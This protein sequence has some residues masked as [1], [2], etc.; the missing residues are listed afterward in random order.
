MSNT[1]GAAIAMV[2]VFIGS[3]AFAI[4]KAKIYDR[5]KKSVAVG[6]VYS[7]KILTSEMKSYSVTVTEVD[8]LDDYVRFTVNGEDSNLIYHW[9]L[10]DFV[11]KFL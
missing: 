2:I 11:E 4:I 3:I 6:N 5:K 1:E 9:N 10:R 7:T 8:Q